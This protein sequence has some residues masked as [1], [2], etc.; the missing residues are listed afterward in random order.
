MRQTRVLTLLSTIV[1]V[2]LLAPTSHL[3]YMY[4]GDSYSS[5]MQHSA[6]FCITL[7][8]LSADGTGATNVHLPADQA[9]HCPYLIL[10]ATPLLADLVDEDAESTHSSPVEVKHHFKDGPFNSASFTSHGVR[11]PPQVEATA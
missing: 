9:Y 1:V 2:G 5:Q 8:V 11:G 4:F 10:F 6:H 7:E 3:I